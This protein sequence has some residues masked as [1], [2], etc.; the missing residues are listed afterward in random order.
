LCRPSNQLGCRD[1][2]LE[3]TYIPIII[4]TAYAY[5][6][7]PNKIVKAIYTT[8]KNFAESPSATTATT[9]RQ[10]IKNKKIARSAQ[11]LPL[12]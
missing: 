11:C 7:T 5:N 8:V 4:V 10:N 9:A 6:A 12:G 3:K 2:Y 1:R